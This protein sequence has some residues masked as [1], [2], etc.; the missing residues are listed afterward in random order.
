MA[1]E[2]GGRIDDDPPRWLARRSDGLWCAT[3]VRVGY[4]EAI[5]AMSARLEALASWAKSAPAPWLRELAWEAR[6]HAFTVFDRGVECVKLSRVRVASPPPTARCSHHAGDVRPATADQP[7][8]HA[9]CGCAALTDGALAF[10]AAEL[11]TALDA[12]LDADASFA[13]V[14]DSAWLGFDGAVLV[15]PRYELRET[16]DGLEYD[17]EG[18]LRPR[19]DLPFVSE[20]VARFGGSMA[21][22]ESA[23]A[24]RP[25][26]GLL[27]GLI[28]TLRARADGSAFSREVQSAMAR[29]HP[30]ARRSLE[31]ALRMLE[32]RDPEELPAGLVARLLDARDD[33]AAWAVAH[34]WMLAERLPRAE[35][36]LA[37]RLPEAE[38]AQQHE[39]LLER[40]AELGPGALPEGVTLTWRHGYVDT[41]ELVPMRFAELSALMRHPSLR[42]V[43]TLRLRT[44]HFVDAVELVGDLASL[45]HDAV[46]RIEGPQAALGPDEARLR[47]AFPRAQF[48]LPATPGRGPA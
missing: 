25:E 41:V 21:G 19:D 39:V 7:A 36:M 34:D 17:D 11:F 40:F 35:L 13:S 43:R 29:E 47:A 33:E 18:E 46:L 15:R 24:S 10:L 32:G 12:G 31:V 30:D 23:C 42:F 28:S 27:A 26:P 8:H 44:S 9:L 14:V 37:E 45:G 16:W 5:A 2:R 6:G 38:R 3:E 20:L 4:V 22:L 48:S 1:F